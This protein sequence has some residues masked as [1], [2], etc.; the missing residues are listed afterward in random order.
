MHSTTCN[1]HHSIPHAWRHDDDAF[2]QDE[3][4]EDNWDGDDAFANEEYW[5]KNEIEIE[6]WKD[7]QM[8]IYEVQCTHCSASAEEPG[9]IYLEGETVRI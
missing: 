2:E 9:R 3:D 1:L 6:K 8:S 4:Y 5:E 7:E